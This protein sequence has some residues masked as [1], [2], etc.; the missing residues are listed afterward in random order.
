MDEQMG[1]KTEP[2]RSMDG[3]TDRWV[4]EWL[5]GRLDWGMSCSVVVIVDVRR[6]N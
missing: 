2:D 5:D 1:R 3:W 4:N 6:L